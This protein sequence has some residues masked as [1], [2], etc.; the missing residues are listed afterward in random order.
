MRIS[1]RAPSPT[2]SSSARAGS[3]SARSA[4]ASPQKRND[5]PAAICT[6]SATLSRAENSGSTEV[7]WNERARPLATRCGMVSP[8]MSS[9]AKRIVPAF[10]AISPESWAIAVV[11]PAPFGP[12]SAWISPSATSRF[13]LSVAVRPPEPLDQA[14]D[15]QQRA[16]PFGPPI[17][18]RNP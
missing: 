11:L 13:R 1:A 2:S 14:L 7:I 16:H 4:R 15:L 9:P 8:V 18:A 6:A 3:R 10:G 12:I 17:P 5:E